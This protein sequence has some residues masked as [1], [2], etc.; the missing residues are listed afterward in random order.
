MSEKNL[1]DKFKKK[2]QDTMYTQSLCGETINMSTIDNQSMSIG[3]VD[4]L[5]HLFG[6]LWHYLLNPVKGTSF[7]NCWY[8]LQVGAL[9]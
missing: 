7:M 9:S 1:N 5:G 4:K 2:I 3:C 8:G 6:F